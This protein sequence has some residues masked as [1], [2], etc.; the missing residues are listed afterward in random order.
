MENSKDGEQHTS[1]AVSLPHQQ[2]DIVAKDPFYVFPED[3]LRFLMNRFD[4]E[5]IEHVDSN[6]TTVEVRHMDV[7]YH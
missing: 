2:F 3:M 6:L 5:F 1:D 7:L 4:F